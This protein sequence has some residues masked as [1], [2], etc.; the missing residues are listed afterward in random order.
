MASVTVVRACLEQIAMASKTDNLVGLPPVC[1]F[2]DTS[3]ISGGSR[4]VSLVGPPPSP[5][6]VVDIRDPSNAGPG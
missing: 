3:P 4:K 1:I 2:V 5:V 6:G